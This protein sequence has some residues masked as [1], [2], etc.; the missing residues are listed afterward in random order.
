MPKT[1]KDEPM[2]AKFLS[3]KVEPKLMKSIKATDEP[4]FINP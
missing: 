2:R 3:D 1:D 4:S